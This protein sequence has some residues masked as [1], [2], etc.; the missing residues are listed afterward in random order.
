MKPLLLAAIAAAVAPAWSQQKLETVIVTG[1]PLRSA[2]VA[3][4][5]SVLFGNGLVL[6]R[7]SSLGETRER[8]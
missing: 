4:P 6:R 1:N 8:P 3:A 5:S 7:G 2:E